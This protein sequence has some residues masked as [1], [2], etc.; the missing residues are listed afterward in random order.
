MDEFTTKENLAEADAHIAA[1]E[2][3]IRRQREIIAKCTASGH[4]IEQA[5][6]LLTTLTQ[7]LQAMLRVRERMISELSEDFRIPK[8]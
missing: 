1:T 7:L 5:E 6:E 8:N 4:S 3:F 2:A